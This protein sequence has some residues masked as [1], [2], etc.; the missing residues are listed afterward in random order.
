MSKKII[1]V[2]DLTG[3]DV[4]DHVQVSIKREGYGIQIGSTTYF[5]DT[6]LDVDASELPDMLKSMSFKKSIQPNIMMASGLPVEAKAAF[7]KPGGDNSPRP[8]IVPV[9]IS[10]VLLES[11][12]YVEKS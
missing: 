1:F 2:S 8:E 4:K 10:Q 6:V 7:F 12:G 5:G 3:K 11:S 9:V